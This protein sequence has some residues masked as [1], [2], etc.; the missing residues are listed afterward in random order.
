MASLSLQKQ[1][2]FI[3]PKLKL[4]ASSALIAQCDPGKSRTDFWDTIVTGFVLECR[5]S[6]GKT[7]YLRYHDAYGTQRQHKI[8]RF[9][10]LTFAQARKT[11]QRL[12]SEV[13]VGGDPQAR[14][15]ERKAI[16]TYGELA[17]RHIAFGRTYLRSHQT[18]EGYLRKHVIPRWGKVR[19]V[20]IEQADVAKWLAEKGETLAPA[21][22]EKIRV[23][24]A[25]SFQ[26]AS[27]WGV[28]GGERNP[29]RAVPRKAFSN[30]RDRYLSA[31][32]AERLSK[33]VAASRNT[34]LKYIVGL[35]LLTGA[36]R[37]ELLNAKWQDVDVQRRMWL[38]P[39]SKSGKARHIPLSQTAVDLIGKLPRFKNCP[40]LLPNPDTLKPFAS[41]KH[42]WQTAREAA[43]L[44][45]VRI[46]DLRHSAASFMINAGIDLYTV[47]KIL[48]HSSMTSTARYSHVA[49]GTLLAAVD[50]GAGKLNLNWVQP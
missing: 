29:V 42:S 12:R 36:R 21:T 39:L 8:G 40:Y 15:E 50:A 28:P 10:D 38:V 37:S 24:F 4:D 46:H 44:G 17:E 2:V 41:I 16:P 45:D 7:Y 6:G 48:G 26:L 22:V 27:Q 25:R 11:A 35:L 33:A 20:D 31:E 32:E 18:N 47:G 9:E 14:K 43:G 34:Q 19:L 13:A 30:A 23:L 49:N 5:S 3:M 1:G